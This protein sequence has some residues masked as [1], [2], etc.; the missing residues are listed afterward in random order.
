[1]PSWPHTRLNSSSGQVHSI[2]Q[3][4]DRQSDQRPFIVSPVVSLT[5]V[6]HQA[7]P[8]AHYFQRCD[9]ESG[10]PSSEGIRVGGTP[11][12]GEASHAIEGR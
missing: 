9:F 7:V 2:G 4:S 6:A 8:G 11:S 3:F 1:M 12:D 10:V 5:W